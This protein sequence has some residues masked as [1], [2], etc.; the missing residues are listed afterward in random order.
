MKGKLFP[1]AFG[2]RDNVKKDK[3]LKERL[4]EARRAISECGEIKSLPYSDFSLYYTTGS[5]G[6]YE[7][8]YFAHRRLLNALAV[9]AASG[10]DCIKELQNI[11]WA[12]ADEFTWAVPAHIPQGISAFECTRQIDLFAAETSFALSEILYIFGD[13]L[14]ET[15]KDR[16]R[17]E[18]RRR[19]LQP[20][21]SGVKNSWDNRTNNWAAVCAGSVGASFL[22]LGS[23]DEIQKVLPR[24]KSTLECYLKGFDDDGA[25]VEGLNYWIYG[26]G[27][28]TYFAELLRNY[29]DGKD[30]LFDNPKVESIAAFQQKIHLKNNNTVTFS[31]S[32][33]RFIQRSGLS[34]FLSKRFD[35]VFALDDTSSL[36]FDGDACYRFAHIIRDFAWRDTDG[37]KMLGDSCG[38]EYFKNAAWYVRK[39]PIIEFAAKA[40]R[41]DE[42]HNHNDIGSFIINADGKS[43]ITDPGKG[44]YTSDYFG[45]KRYT[46]FA[47][48][49][50]AHSVP[51]INGKEQSGGEYFGEII[52]ADNNSLVIDFENAYD[53]KTL[54]KL[55]RSFDFSDSGIKLCDEFEFCEIPQSIT[56]HFV[57]AVKPKIQGDTIIMGDI[58]VKLDKG[59]FDCRISEKT[60]STGHHQSKTVYLTDMC[61]KSMQKSVTAEFY[62][63]L[64]G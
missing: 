12:I 22:Y 15:I 26:F 7:D 18:V 41:N 16:I 5:R 3:F 51:V 34:H 58:T 45:E 19:V 28:Y 49:S 33:D 38:F 4:N 29:T 1:E 56:E 52:K 62:F 53:D 36:G 44:E 39:A 64:K 55:R 31:D 2:I 20:Y 30:N 48:S 60:F 23:D 8:K 57:S 24:I 17:Y 11:L 6:E 42:S 10:D 63:S 46:Y 14:D 27:Y 50:L 21:L 43:V 35:G 47:P 40:G 54:K 61:F 59:S 9:A 13:V 37:A 25:C 32:G